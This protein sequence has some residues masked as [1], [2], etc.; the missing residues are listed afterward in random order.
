MVSLYWVYDIP[1]SLFALLCIGVFVAFGL[2][3]LPLTRRFVRRVH[4]VD[5]SHNEIVGFYLAAVTVF[6]G[7]TLGLVAVGTW[8]NY[9][10]VQDRVDHE[11][12]TLASLYRDVDGYPEPY[13]TKMTGDLKSYANEVIY[14]SWPQQRRGIIPF[15]TDAIMTKIQ[16]ELFAYKPAD[17][18]EQVLQ[19][20][21]LE[22]FNRLGEARRARIDSVY[23]SLSPAL[24][25]MVIL[26]ALTCIVVTFFFDMRSPSMHRWMTGLMGGLLGLMIFLIAVLD[27][28]FRGKV[29]VEPESMERVYAV[30]MK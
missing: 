11:A 27:N 17:L 13:R 28:P 26:G 3:G 10:A 25:W 19:A 1:N 2:L 16:R 20:Q 4:L 18:G 5:H 8:T 30:V 29:S 7:I 21:A 9:S 12:Q 22:T 14:S 15:G 24:W 6:Y 23:M